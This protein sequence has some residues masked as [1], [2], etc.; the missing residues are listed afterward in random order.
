MQSFFH[1]FPAIFLLRELERRASW[2]LQRG[3]RF[4]YL[5]KRAIVS[6]QS[7]K[8]MIMK[9]EITRHVVGAIPTCFLYLTVK[10]FKRSRRVE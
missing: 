9:E 1:R 6:T 2:S 5:I 10:G 3:Q 7:Q 4:Q 8:G